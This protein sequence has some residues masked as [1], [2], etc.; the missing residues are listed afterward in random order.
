MN[1]IQ[2]RKEKAEDK[3]P[4]VLLPEKLLMKSSMPKRRD[5]IRV[6]KKIDLRAT[7]TRRELVVATENAPFGISR[8]VNTSRRRNVDWERT[9]ST[10]TLQSGRS[11][12]I[13]SKEEVKEK[14]LQ[15]KGLQLL[16][17]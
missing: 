2:Q 15:Q 14:G 5:R 4:E 1:T 12:H 7:A 16:C 9:V 10:P 11:F 17:E 6:A 3:D 8:T 13:F